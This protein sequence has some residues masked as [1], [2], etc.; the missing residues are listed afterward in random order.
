MTTTPNA[1]QKEFWAR[2]GEEWVRQAARYD[3]M[4][5]KFGEAMLDAAALQPGER[6]LDVGCGNGATSL[7]AARRVQP[8]GAVVGVDLSAPM[9]GLARQRASEAGVANAEFVEHD[10]QVHQFEPGAFDVVVSRF[11]VMFFDDPEAAFATLAGAVRPG[12]RLAMVVWEDVFKSEW[13]IVPGAAAAEHVGFP[14]LGP[15]GAP[16]PFAFADGDRL[17]GILAGAGF[18]D[19]RLEAITRPMRIGDDVDDVT[20]FITS[21]ELVRD[22]L[23]AGKPEDKVAAAIAAAR[24]A[25]APYAGP[26]GVVMNATAWL[27]TAR[28]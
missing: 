24:E 7:E 14:D 27:A 9:L 3:A 21:L 17:K 4:N 25:V 12:G 1:E 15:P 11:G 18:S 28:R 16:G 2:E 20:E 10:A 22:L 23:F 6:V 19:I 5:A 13:I 26:D 8:G